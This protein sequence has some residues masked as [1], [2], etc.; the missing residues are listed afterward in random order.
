MI[1]NFS[2]SERTFGHRLLRGLQ[3]GGLKRGKKSSPVVEI[4]PFV[5]T[6]NAS[7]SSVIMLTPTSL[8]P[9]RS[10]RLNTPLLVGYGTHCQEKER[11]GV[12]QILAQFDYHRDQQGLG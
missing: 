10:S 8:G 5:P 9:S 12:L 1:S 3:N 7:K 6:D 11:G 4:G 2:E